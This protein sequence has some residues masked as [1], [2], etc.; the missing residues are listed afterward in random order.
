MNYRNNRLNRTFLSLDHLAKKID[1]GK[2]PFVSDG[3]AFVEHL[4]AHLDTPPGEAERLADE[5][6]RRRAVRLAKVMNGLERTG[7]G[8]LVPV[9]RLIAE[10]GN[11]RTAS[12]A[13]LAK[14]RG[15]SYAAAKVLYFRHRKTLMKLLCGR[16]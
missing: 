8:Y 1:L 3:G 10:H 12:I 15:T 14:E 13:A 7:R 6:E 4:T 2:S 16:N 5:E 11:D 9:L